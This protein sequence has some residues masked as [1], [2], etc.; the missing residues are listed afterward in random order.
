[1]IDLK[2]DAERR[3]F[4]DNEHIKFYY[5]DLKFDFVL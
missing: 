3:L 4:F 5:I 1:V 2:K